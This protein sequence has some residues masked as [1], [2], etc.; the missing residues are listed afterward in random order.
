MSGSSSET[1][2]NQLLITVG[3]RIIFGWTVKT[4]TSSKSAIFED[5]PVTSQKLYLHRFCQLLRYRKTN[6]TEVAKP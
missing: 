4:L 1:V 2:Q 3:C 6:V 5:L